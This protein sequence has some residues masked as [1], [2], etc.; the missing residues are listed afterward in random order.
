MGFPRHVTVNCSP[1]CNWLRSTVTGPAAANVRRLGFREEINGTNAHATPT[2]PKTCILV[3]RNLR[4]CVSTREGD[5]QR[6]QCL[7]CDDLE[8]AILRAPN[9]FLRSTYESD[10]KKQASINGIKNLGTLD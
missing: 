3:R 8:S 2:Q 9:V 5:E 6:E 7:E 4:F 1:G 10:M